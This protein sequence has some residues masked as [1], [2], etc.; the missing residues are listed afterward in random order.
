MRLF[1]HAKIITYGTIIGLS[2]WYTV[3][4]NGKDY[5]RCAASYL[6]THGYRR[7]KITGNSS[8]Y[9]VDITAHRGGHRYA[10]QCKFY[11]HPVGVAA[12]QQ[13][14]GGMAY[15]NCDRAMVITNTTF[16]RQARELA[17][18]NEVELL[19]NIRSSGKARRLL[20]MIFYMLALILLMFT[21]YAL[22]AGITLGISVLLLIF[23]LYLR[24][25]AIRSIRSE[26]DVSPHQRT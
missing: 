6:R 22:I 21:R 14:V 9:G 4:M 19:D 23:V 25:G 11:S 16:T 3:A 13:V 5:E 10:V 2:I 12:V 1:I 17:G 15:Y 7:V 8:D 26:N 20:L 24:H 18:R